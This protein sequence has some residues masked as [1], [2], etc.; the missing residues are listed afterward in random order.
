MRV[1][2]GRPETIDAD[3]TASIE[4]LE[5]VAETGEPAVRVWRPHRQLAF[6]RRDTRAPGY[7]RAV[8][9][10]RD[11]GFPPV[12]RSVGGHAVAY[13]GS[14]V[15]FA[16]AE[17]ISDIR[18]GLD[19]RYGRATRTIRRALADLGVETDTGEPPNSFCPGQHSLQRRGKLVGLAQR[20]KTGAAVT[21]G[22]VVVRDHDEVAAVLDPVYD[23]LD[24]P[25]DPG[26]VGS[27][28]KAGGTSDPDAVVST[29]ERAL[30]GSADVEVTPIAEL[31]P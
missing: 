15:A 6:G 8:A 12:S 2:R 5:N 31:E 20:I 11:H 10:A 30:V 14:T 28:A 9:A 27:I 24:I 16:H 17:P 26:S 3:R 29:I 4:M 19:D 7:E 18:V 21:A 23:A 1:L 25:F 22:V 13:T